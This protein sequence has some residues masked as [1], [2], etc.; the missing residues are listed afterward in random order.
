MRIVKG[1]IYSKY[2]KRIMDFLFS[3]VILV[4]ISPIMVMVGIMV[5]INLGSPVFFKQKRPGLNE[6]IFYIYKF[7]T[8]TN[9]TDEKGNLLPDRLRLTSFGRVLRKTSLDELPQLINII[10]GEMSFIGPRPF[11]VKHLK[12]YNFQQ[13]RRH[14]VRPGLSGLAQINGRNNLS[15]EKTL[16]LDIQYV[17]NINFYHDLKITFITILKVIK[18][19]GIY[20][21]EE[22]VTRPYKRDAL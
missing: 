12:L 10:K 17:E 9:E 14:E 15:W 6:D 11:L 19:E 16:E 7:R 21:D 8:M 18:R 3:L 2:F 4:V 1:E 22:K 13:R 5:K 20:Q